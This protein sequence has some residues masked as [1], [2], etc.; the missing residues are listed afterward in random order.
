MQHSILHMARYWST[1]I[2]DHL[3]MCKGHIQS[4]G[5]GF[6][7]V[8]AWKGTRR[9]RP[10]AWGCVRVGRRIL[11][12][13]GLFLTTWTVFSD[14]SGALYLKYQ[15]KH[16]AVAAYVHGQDH[17]GWPVGGHMQGF[18]TSVLLFS[19]DVRNTFPDVALDGRARPPPPPPRGG[20]RACLTAYVT[21]ENEEKTKQWMCLVSLYSH[22]QCTCDKE[23]R[24]KKNH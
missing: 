17:V 15:K 18:H 7:R 13:A 14:I 4:K 1:D 3:G 5:W 16:T 11:F 10:E 9:L 22:F 19:L 2:S 24:G 21:Q 12:V 8:F 23:I 6:L 20:G